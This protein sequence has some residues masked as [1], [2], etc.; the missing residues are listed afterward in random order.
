MSYFLFCHYCLFFL[1]SSPAAIAATSL[2]SSFDKDQDI[3][4]LPMDLQ[5][6]DTHGQLTQ[7]VL[8]HFGKVLHP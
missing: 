6:F 1:L 7:D 4:V 2:D 3:I 5:K 8:K